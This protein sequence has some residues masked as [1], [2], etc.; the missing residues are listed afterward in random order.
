MK[1][2]EK[3]KAYFAKGLND[4]SSFTLC[5][6]AACCWEFGRYGVCLSSDYLSFM[7]FLFG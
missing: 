7:P 4:D 5:M 1:K 6:E 2:K 3:V